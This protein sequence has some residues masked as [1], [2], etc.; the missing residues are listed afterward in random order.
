MLISNINFNCI[1][2]IGINPI[3]K[4]K[5][6]LINQEDEGNFRRNDSSSLGN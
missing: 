3:Q 4:M 1:C 5:L 2:I 6:N